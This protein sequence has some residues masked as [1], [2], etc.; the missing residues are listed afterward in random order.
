MVDHNNF[1]KNTRII[2]KTKNEIQSIFD[3][4]KNAKIN[5]L[6]FKFFYS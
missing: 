3:N 2:F 4:N 1:V 6:W 5:F